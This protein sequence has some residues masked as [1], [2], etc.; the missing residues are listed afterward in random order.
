MLLF[1]C[2][3]KVDIVV[4]QVVKKFLVCLFRFV[5][6]VRKVCGGMKQLW[7]WVILVRE[8]VCIICI[9]VGIE[10]GSL[11]LYVLH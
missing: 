10:L 8:L 9:L 3:D 2:G 7:G 5:V 1:A 6:E 4:F 11:Q